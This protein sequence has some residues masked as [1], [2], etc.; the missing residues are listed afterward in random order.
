MKKK[1]NSSNYDNWGMP[2]INMPYIPD[3]SSFIN[4]GQ[5]SVNPLESGVR[6]VTNTTSFG[7][8]NYDKAP[9]FQKKRRSDTFERGLRLNS[10]EAPL[11]DYELYQYQNDS[12]YQGG[13]NK[14]PKTGL[15]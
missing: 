8:D 4:E 3:L 11:S 7:F 9:K 12:D 13:K 2:K 15:F 14:P 5:S 10:G 1:T 6:K